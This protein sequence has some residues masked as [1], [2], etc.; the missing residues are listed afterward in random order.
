M[1][2]IKVDMTQ[3]KIGIEPFV[4]DG[5]VGGRAFIDHWMS[6]YVSP[7]LHPLCERNPFIIAPGL[8]AG[9]SAPSSGRLSIGGKSPLTGG[10][11]E[12]NVGGT[13][14]HKLGRLG[15][16]GIVIEGRAKEWQ[17]LKL[18]AKGATLE[19]A[20]DIVGLD[21]YVACERLFQRYGDKMGIIITGPAGEMRLTN[22]TV[23]V[24][25]MEGRPCRHAGRGGVGAIMGAK[26]LKAILVDDTGSSLRKPLDP[27]AFGVAVKAA[28]EAINSGPYRD[29]MHRMGTP[30]M[31]DIDNARGSLPSYNYHSGAFDKVQNIGANKI[32]ELNQVR[33]GETGHGCMPGC[34]VRCSTTFHDACGKFVTASLEY[35][36]L[37][38][39]GANLGI[40]DIDAIAR[41]DRNCDGL[42]IDTIEIGSTIG[43]LND[44]GLFEFGDSEKAE[45]LIEEIRKRTPLGRILGSGV[46]LAS[47]VFGIDRVPAVKGQAIP[48]HSAR[49][50][51]G[52]GVTYA[53]SPQGADH[54]AGSVVA[55]LLSPFGQ[56]ERSRL[57]QII[58]TAIDATGLCQFTFLFKNPAPVIS[59][60][61][62]FYGLNLTMEDFNEIG[63]RMLRQERAFNIE[64]GIGPCADRLPD[65]MRN[66]PLPPTNAVFDVS[67]E[68]INEFW[69][70]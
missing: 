26:L 31:I 70:F 15:V 47:R 17:I 4:E 68:E 5:L 1:T 33:K 16:Q 42:G 8:F 32:I 6:K 52:W 57:S 2:V 23:A 58:N 29:F 53:T 62:A 51:K 67:Q 36:T 40:D 45:A 65:W 11:K 21:N 37:V 63:M 35:E 19:P 43:I 64:A 25:D 56:V 13:V 38:M 24:S 22:S 66:E 69:K 41:M 14:G 30:G 48:A 46:E 12:A 49:S 20:G 28:I 54:T 27:V 7:T 55:E 44:V 10:I 39:L 3:G 18:D 61:N 9:T 50:M 34:A 59:M 60:I